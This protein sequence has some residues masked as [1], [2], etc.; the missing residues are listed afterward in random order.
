MAAYLANVGVNASHA[1][2]SRLRQDGSFTLLPIPETTPW[3][4]PM[5]RLR[6]ACG[7]TVEVPRGWLDRAVHADP[8]LR[9]APATYGDNCATAGRAYSLRAAQPGDTIFFV[10]R[11]HPVYA[12]AGFYLVGRLRIDAVAA[13]LTKDPGPGWWNANAHVRRARATGAWNRFWVFRGDQSSGF[14]SAAIPFR[15]ADAELVFGGWTWSQTRSELQT[16]ASHTRA[17]RRLT[18]AA[19]AA[20]VELA[21]G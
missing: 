17:V 19:E 9:S 2:R 12:A 20:L 21:G 13:N 5:L 8:D 3:R 4:A 16:I 1:A 6:D 11:L 7:D 14:L 15:K 10:A 18:G